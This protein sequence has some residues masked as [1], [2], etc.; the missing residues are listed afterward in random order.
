[1]ISLSILMVLD[2]IKPASRMLFWAKSTLAP[3]VGNVAIR[4]TL[5]SVLDYSHVAR[6]SNRLIYVFPSYQDLL[7]EELKRLQ[8]NVLEDAFKYLDNS[9][10]DIESSSEVGN[11][12]ETV[13]KILIAP[14]KMMG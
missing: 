6:G 13:V 7:R 5:L 14:N 3:L 12:A 10:F 4:L 9:G 11:L 2:G 1:V 8:D